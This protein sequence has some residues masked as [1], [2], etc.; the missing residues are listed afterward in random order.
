MKVASRITAALTAALLIGLTGC[1]DD[2]TDVPE[3][4]DLVFTGDASFQ[5]A[6]GGQAIEAAI[7]NSA[8]TVVATDAGTVS[9]SAD[10]SF[11]FTFTNALV[12]G[13][14][15][16]LHYWIDSNFGSGATVGV[17]DA[18]ANDHQWSIDVTTVTADVTIAD[19][20]RPTDTE[21]VCNTFS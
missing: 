17:C 14:S 15:Y 12:E 1:D 4:F 21:P 20:H 8:G 3:T 11:S 18:P 2:G 19:V 16:E 7:V 9:A 5:A 10:P 13:Q 6:H